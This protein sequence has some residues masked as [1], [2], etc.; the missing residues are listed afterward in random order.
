MAAEGRDSAR[1]STMRTIRKSTRSGAILEA[2]FVVA[3]AGGW[4]GRRGRRGR[5]S[6]ERRVSDL[7]W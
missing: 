6:E 1:G 7:D 4:R 3:G 5:R 2:L